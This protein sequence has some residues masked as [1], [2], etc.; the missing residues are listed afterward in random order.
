V[1]NRATWF[2][3]IAR[4]YSSYLIIN[5][6]RIKAPSTQVTYQDIDEIVLDILDGMSLR[7]KAA[8]AQLDEGDVPYLQYAFDKIVGE[9]DELGRNVMHLIWKV[10][11]KTHRVRVVK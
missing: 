9:N 4:Q 11:Q 2:Q 1:N 6:P 8:I 5:L 7:D 10:L 3:L